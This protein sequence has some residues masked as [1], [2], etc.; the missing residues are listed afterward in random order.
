MSLQQKDP[1][2]RLTGI[3]KSFPGVKALDHVN[4]T[5][6][7]GEV[8]ALAG[9]NG[10]GKSTLMK[11]LSG[12]YSKDAGTIE[13]DGKTVEI[14]SP[15]MAEELGLSII[16]QELNVLPNLTVAENIYLG[17]QPCRHGMID[18]KQMNQSAAALFQKLGIHLDV[19]VRTRKL[20]VAQQ[21]M[22]EIAKAVSYDTKLVI[23]DEPTSSLTDQ[24]T[25][26]LF[27][28]IKD[29]SARGIAVIFITHRMEEIFTIADRVTVL[30][31]GCYI[32]TKTISET[33]SGELISM[34][35]GRTL[36]QQYPPR[37]VAQGEVILRVDHL[38]DGRKVKDIAYIITDG[39]KAPNMIPDAASVWYNLRADDRDQLMQVYERVRQIAAGAATMSGTTVAEEFLGCVYNPL[40][41][42]ELMRVVEKAF[43]AIPAEPYTDDEI[44]YISALNE[45][46]PRTWERNCK[47]YHLPPKTPYLTDVLPLF[48]NRG[49]TD[50]GDVNHVC[51]G[52][53]FRTMCY[54]MGVQAHT[55]AAT[56]ITNH[57]FA[58]KGMIRGSKIIAWTA[59]QIFQ[60]P[61]ICDRAKAEFQEVTHGKPYQA[62]LPDTPPANI[63]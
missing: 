33:N 16:H 8:M 4:L 60:D 17:R 55:W 62:C 1:I 13:F 12:S 2:L 47:Q 54:P 10:A 52:V 39:G 45:A 18:W 24:E 22:V 9:E 15:K 36:T 14:T 49:S 7:R 20:S 40:N 30:R 57:S 26:I 29:L 35:I 31:D 27:R 21:Q 56:A 63:F 58:K 46:N 3:C 43:D 25:Q 50:V 34:M 59:M 23:M 28:I 51:P 44:A 32:G 61:S 41:N 6:L 37:S 48:Y 38:S 42:R 53:S 11:I 5:V 19:T